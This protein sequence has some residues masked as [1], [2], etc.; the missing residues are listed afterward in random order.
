LPNLAPPDVYLFG[1]GNKCLIAL[2]F[3][4]TQQFF[5]AVQNV[6]EGIEK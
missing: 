1:Y 5:E 3:E 6:L 4:G 2:S